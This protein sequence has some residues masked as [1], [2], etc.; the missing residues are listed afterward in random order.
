MSLWEM[1]ASGMQF[2]TFYEGLL[3]MIAV[4]ITL[5]S[6]GMPMIYVGRLEGLWHSPILHQH[7]KR[8]LRQLTAPHQEW[9]PC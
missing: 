1:E 8:P 2:A 7:A 5:D 9:L 4:V 3:G 6:I